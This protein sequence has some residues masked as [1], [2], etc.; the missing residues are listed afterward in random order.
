M[1]EE[2]END[3]LAQIRDLATRNKKI[4]DSLDLSREE[5]Q[6]TWAKLDKMQRKWDHHEQEIIE[7]DTKINDLQTKLSK[8]KADNSDLNTVAKKAKKKEAQ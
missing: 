8:L 5:V 4:Q 3:L 2:R 1:N 7:R 6:S